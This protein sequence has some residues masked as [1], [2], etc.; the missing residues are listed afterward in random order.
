MSNPRL[1]LR[2]DAFAHAMRIKAA[3]EQRGE[4]ADLRQHVER[5]PYPDEPIARAVAGFCDRLDE[6]P[7]RSARIAAAEA[8]VAFIDTLNTPVPPGHDRKDFY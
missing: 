6:A 7:D 1:A 2:M 8:M 5:Y 4:T 3:T